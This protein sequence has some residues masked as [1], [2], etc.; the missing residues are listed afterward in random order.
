[1]IADLKPGGRYT[2]VDVD[3]AGGSKL[4]AKRLHR[5]RPHRRRPAHG[6]GPDPRRG[7]RGRG[8]EPGQEVIVGR[9][10]AAQASGGLVILK[11]NLAPEGCVV[12]VAGYTRLDHTRPGPRLRPEEDAMAAVQAG[13]ISPTTWS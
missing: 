5:R 7:G 13:G 11:G 12:K 9:R 6:H 4:L 10:R 3:R 1:M 8:G 2:A